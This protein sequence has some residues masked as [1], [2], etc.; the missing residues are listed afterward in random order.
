[1]G[2]SRAMK[3]ALNWFALTV[4]LASLMT[5]LAFSLFL[6]ASWLS[7]AVIRHHWRGDDDWLWLMLP[8]GGVLGLWL[9][10]RY[11]RRAWIHV[12]SGVLGSGVAAFLLHVSRLTARQPG[13][14]GEGIGRILAVWLARVLLVTGAVALA[15]AGVAAALVLILRRYL[16]TRAN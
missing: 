13:D 11:H 16:T 15:V 14:L 8:V 4:S 1:M 7:E 5:G 3:R 2:A 6:G 12:T 10:L 9:G